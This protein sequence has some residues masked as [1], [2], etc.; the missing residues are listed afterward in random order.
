M[1][2]LAQLLIPA[3]RWDATDGYS[4]AQEAVERALALGV[5][6]FILFGGTD[7]AVAALTATTQRQATTP[8]LFMSDLERGAGQQF[9]G[10]TGLPPLGAIGAMDDE[11]QTR[12]AARVTAREAAALGVRTILAP[13]ADV[14]LE[15]DNPIVGTRAFG[16]HPALVGHHVRAW[17]EECQ[18]QGAMACV[19]HFPGHGRTRADSHAELPI[20][21][22]TEA[23]LEGSDLVPFEQAIAAGVACVMTA[24]VA[25]RA[26]DATMAPATLS[27][28]ITRDL[29]RDRMGFAG[30][31]LTDA[32]IM[33][34]VLGD[35]DEDQAAVRALAAGCDLLLYPDDPVRVVAALEDAV[36]SR[37]LSTRDLDRSLERRHDWALWSQSQ[38]AAVPID[39]DVRAAAEQLSDQS[40]RVLRGRVEPTPALD[41]VL[42]D[43]DRGGPYPPPSRTP[44]LE[45]LGAGGFEVRIVADV[46]PRTL[47]PVES[48]GQ[49]GTLSTLAGPFRPQATPLIAVFN[50][51]R[52]WKGTPGF[53]RHAELLIE[54][55]LRLAQ[56]AGREAIVLTFTHPRLAARID[57]PCHVNAWGG[58]APTQRAMGRFLARRR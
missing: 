36:R 20:V 5:G 34:G 37:Q 57:A 58:E 12:L 24:H 54:Q 39:A 26:L 6:G 27:R 42:I 22:A 53:S 10:G 25:Y 33:S 45:S 50:D 47:P 51:I 14:D 43:D 29:L 8:L 13:V 1:S 44:L 7:G 19:K 21:E 40:V 32:M 41:V 48:E 52:A 49:P 30:L 55:A 31:V 17:V 4:R 3:V 16:G 2:D 46:A 18:Q 15:P 56:A 9:S 28:R 23:E 38:P 35:G 11:A